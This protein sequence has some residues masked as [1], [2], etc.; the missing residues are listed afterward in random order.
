MTSIVW[1]SNLLPF[2]VFILVINLIPGPDVT[3]IIQQSLA[4]GRKAGV[5]ATLGIT[6]GLCCHLFLATFG[7]TKLMVEFKIFLHI[8]KFV[9]ISYLCYLAYKA[10]IL[11]D[12]FT[13][14]VNVENDKNVLL[15]ALLTNLLNPKVALVFVSI[16]PQF[17]HPED[18]QAAKILTFGLIFIFTGS[19]I[20][21]LFCYA[22]IAIAFFNFGNSYL[23]CRI[24]IF[25]GI[26]FIVLGIHLALFL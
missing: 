17:V 8:F 23:A 13:K 9:G 12:I 16:L 18:M 20:N 19:C 6:L 22:S 11:T 24:N 14:N 5:T 25:C 10:F 15:S 1:D 21:L 4:G 26:I 7:I 3:Y 2:L